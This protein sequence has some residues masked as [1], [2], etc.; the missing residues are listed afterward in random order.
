MSD[1]ITINPTKKQLKALEEAR[2]FWADIAKE[3]GWYEEPFYVQVWMNDNDELDD[4]VS[5]AGLKQDI[6]LKNRKEDDE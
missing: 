2:I 5:F 6:L 4:S 1:E 3:N